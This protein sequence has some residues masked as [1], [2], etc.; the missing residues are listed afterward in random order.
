MTFPQ[1]QVCPKVRAEPG[2]YLKEI[3]VWLRF[4]RLNS[5]G[6]KSGKVGSSGA[7]ERIARL[8]ITVGLF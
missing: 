8:P 6:H 3:K 7:G 2:V 1:C 5:D 4:Y